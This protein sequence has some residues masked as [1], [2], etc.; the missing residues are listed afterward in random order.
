MFKSGHLTGLF[1]MKQLTI[2]MN[3]ETSSLIWHAKVIMYSN[4][5]II[6]RQGRF[7]IW[8]SNNTYL[9]LANGKYILVGLSINFIMRINENDNLAIG[10]F[11]LNSY[12]LRPQNHTSPGIIKWQY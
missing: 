6:L 10:N 7:G 4:G 2:K 3:K 9:L 1:W 8:F 12:F 5:H 11:C